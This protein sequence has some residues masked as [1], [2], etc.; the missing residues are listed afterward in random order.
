M[1]AGPDALRGF[2]E[3]LASRWVVPLKHLKTNQNV[4]VGLRHA[5]L[6]AASLSILTMSLGSRIGCGFARVKIDSIAFLP[7]NSKRSSPTPTSAS[8]LGSPSSAT[9]AAKTSLASRS[10]APNAA[11]IDF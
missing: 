1:A 6:Q 8:F 4:R 11:A 2:A 5:G 3:G 7:I 9:K 10:G